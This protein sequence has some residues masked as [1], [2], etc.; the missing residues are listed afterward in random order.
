MLEFVNSSKIAEVG[1]GHGVCWA[2][3]CCGLSSDSMSEEMMS[4]AKWV[5]TSKMLF[6]THCLTIISAQRQISLGAKHSR[7]LI[8]TISNLK[9]NDR[10]D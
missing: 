6:F 4:I 3:L 8:G 5:S 10:N 9:M 7:T 2:S 1:M